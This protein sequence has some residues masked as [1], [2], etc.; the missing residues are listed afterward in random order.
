MQVEEIYKYRTE[1]ASFKDDSQPQNTKT[2]T[3]TEKREGKSNTNAN[4]ITN[5]KGL[6]IE[7]YR[8]GTVS[9]NKGHW[10]FKPVVGC[11]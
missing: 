7:P 3:Q 11:T 9:G 10:G 2:N 5:T 8:L 6:T 1:K 4:D